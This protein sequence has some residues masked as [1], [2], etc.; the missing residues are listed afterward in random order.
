MGV[1]LYRSK[2]RRYSVLD[3]KSVS[4]TFTNWH[5]FWF[6]WGLFLFCFCFYFV[7]LGGSF[8]PS[9]VSLLLRL[10]ASCL[11]MMLSR[12]GTKKLEWNME[13]IS[14]TVFLNMFPQNSNNIQIRPSLMVN[15][16]YL[17]PYYQDSNL[18][19]YYL[20]EI[21]VVSVYFKIGFMICVIY[22]DQTIKMPF[23]SCF[24][25]SGFDRYPQNFLG[26]H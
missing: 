11:Y 26:V 14:I 9:L 3:W 6:L 23:Y 7:E 25:D 1:G 17:C 18:N 10:S 2:A 20:L 15:Y 13:T 4:F 12:S 22:S 8:G 5:K 21:L 16:L 24:Q 19:Q